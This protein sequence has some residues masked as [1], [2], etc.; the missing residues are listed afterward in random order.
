MK[1]VLAIVLLM[2]PMLASADHLDVF[3][4]KFNG[5]CSFEKYMA[6]VKDFNQWGAKNDYKAEILRP[7]QSDNLVSMYWVG[8]SKNAAAFG[9]AWDAWRNAVADPNSVESKLLARLMACGSNI[10]RTGYDTY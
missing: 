3:E 10:S 9:K 5:S 2:S 1:I 4:F 8:R 6:V 7:I